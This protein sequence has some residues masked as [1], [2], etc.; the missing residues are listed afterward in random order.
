MRGAENASS[1]E[2]TP[3]DRH[4]QAALILGLCERVLPSLHMAYVQA[5]FGRDRSGFDLLVRHIAANFGTGIHRRRG[6]EQIIRSYCGEKGGL[7][8]IKK[9]MS[10][11][12][13]KAASLRNRGYDALDAIHSQAM[14]VLW[15]EMQ[16]R[17]LLVAGA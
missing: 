3:Y 17:M 12:L 2:L 14:G 16:G 4:A 7:R 15:D 10:T 5:Q 8:E 9:S 13:L 6:I 1:D 11:G